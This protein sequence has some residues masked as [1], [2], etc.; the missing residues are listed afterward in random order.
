MTDTS[1]RISA[2]DGGEA[3]PE[4]FAIAAASSLQDVRPLVL[5]HGDGFAVFNSKGDVRADTV[6][7]EGVYYRDTRHL[8][9]LALTIERA[10]PLLLSSSLRDDNATLTCD[11]TNPDLYDSDGRLDLAHDLI[12]L[13]RTRFLWKTACFERI[14]VRNFDE[15]PRQSKSA[16]NS[17][18]TLPICLKSAGFI[19]R[20]GANCIPR[21]SKATR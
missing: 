17:P 11:L 20:G 4:Q 2:A 6:G 9:I 14:R 12:H 13:R 1:T 5:K 3:G 18:P 19:G 21:G 16:S 8:S 15:Q 10:P 7:A